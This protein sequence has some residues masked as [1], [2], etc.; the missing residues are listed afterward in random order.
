MTS[1]DAALLGRLAED[2]VLSLLQGEKYQLVERNFRCR[3][4]EID[5][6]MTIG[7][8]AELRELVFVEV[9]YRKRHDFGDGGESVDRRKQDRLRFAA[10]TWLQKNHGFPFRYCRFDVV[11]VSGEAPDLEVDWIQDAF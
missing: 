8:S 4:G 9:R 7:A 3:G 5:L 1:T 6:I 11:S 10:E 2:H